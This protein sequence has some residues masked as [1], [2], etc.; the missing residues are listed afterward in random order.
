MRRFNLMNTPGTDDVDEESASER[1]G[2]PP[3]RRRM[4]LLCILLVLVAAIGFKSFIARPIG[5]GIG[6]YIGN[7]IR[8]FFGRGGKASVPAPAPTGVT[9]SRAAPSTLAVPSLP[10]APLTSARP[11]AAAGSRM[12]PEAGRPVNLP[13]AKTGVEGVALLRPG[14]SAEA[15]KRVTP[16]AVSHGRYSVQLAAMAH[17]ANAI[18]LA[19]KLEKLG[20]DVSIR[21]RRA[22]PSEHIVLVESPRDKT[23]ADAQVERLKVEGIQAVVGESNGHFRVEVGRLAMLDEAIDL[24]HELQK[25]GFIPKIVSETKSNTLFMVRVGEFASRSEAGKS[26]KELREKGFQTILVEK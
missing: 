6:G 15:R 1:G 7:E 17:E 8:G 3:S 19:R 9:P 24:A 12:S 22:S 26:A 23:E 14:Q 20:Y 5:K 18:A 13:S 21:E 16:R 4:F 25:K 10:S 2:V 11:P